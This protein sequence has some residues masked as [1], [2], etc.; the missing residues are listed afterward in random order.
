[1]HLRNTFN[2]IEVP[3]EWYLTFRREPAQIIFY[4]T[5]HFNTAFLGSLLILHPS[6]CQATTANV[7]AAVTQP[8]VCVCVGRLRCGDPGQSRPCSSQKLTTSSTSTFPDVGISHHIHMLAFM[9][10]IRSGLVSPRQLL[11]WTLPSPP[12]NSLCIDDFF[13]PRDPVSSSWFIPSFCR[14][15]SSKCFM[16]KGSWVVVFEPMC[17]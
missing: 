10:F 1:M 12:S 15:T 4:S 11:S 17:V 2:F 8:R 7:P 9:S 6:A 16:R 3:L 14:G 5:G 13:Y